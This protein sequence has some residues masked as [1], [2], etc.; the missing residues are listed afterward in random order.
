MKGLII[1]KMRSDYFTNMS[2]VFNL[3]P[4]EELNFMWL[5]SN[6]ECNIYPSEQIPFDKDYVWMKGTELKEILNQKEIMFIWG[7]FTSYSSDTELKD[8]LKYRLPFADG[9][10]DLWRKD[11]QL[12]NPLSN[13]ELISWDGSVFL[14]LSKNTSIIELLK[15]NYPDNEDLSRYNS[16]ID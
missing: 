1:N 7:N 13:T 14:A 15:N 6:Y 11:I 12:S 4:E 2:E 5:I 9:N 16:D 8:V 10:K 3:L